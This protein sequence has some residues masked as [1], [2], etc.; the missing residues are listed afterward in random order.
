MEKERASQA[1][2]ELQDRVN[3]EL[4]KS[5]DERLNS[6]LREEVLTSEDAF[7]VSARAQ[8]VYDEGLKIWVRA[9]ADLVRM[10]NAWYSN[11]NEIYNEGVGAWAEAL[12]VLKQKR[13]E[14]DEEFSGRIELGLANWE[15]VFSEAGEAR[16]TL[17]SNYVRYKEDR[18]RDLNA[19]IGRPDTEGQFDYLIVVLPTPPFLFAIAIFLK[20]PLPFPLSISR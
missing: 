4:G 16:E 5:I 9:A 15:E 7:A 11:Y 13:E 20:P 6:L 14:W 19:Y 8:N 2:E 17:V 10:E 18:E 3:Q 12:G 1:T